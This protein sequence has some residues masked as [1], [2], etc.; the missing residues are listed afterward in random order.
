MKTPLEEVAEDYSERPLDFNSENDLQARLYEETREYLNSKQELETTQTHGFTIQDD[1]G[2]P[3]YAQRYHRDLESSLKQAPLSRVRTELTVW[4]PLGQMLSSDERPLD[5][6]DRT[7]ILDLAVLK[8]PF[9]RPVHLQNGRH[10]IEIEMVETAVE[11]KYPRNLPCMPS[12]TQGSIASL[13]D[14]EL[15]QTVDFE[16]VGIAADIEELE[17]LGKDYTITP[18]LFIS[19]QYD[20]FRR[21]RYTENRHQLLADAAV[22]KLRN[23]CSRT[24]V[25]YS[26]PD[27]YEWLV[28]H[29]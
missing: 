14:A 24:S 3:A 16:R 15:R 6:D 29:H 20:I 5:K 7:E 4:H 13:S 26:Y 2:Q 23:K 11:L 8:D 21:G 22:E 17:S 25:L 12:N 27:G 18:Y 28:D 19:S 9:D 10:R 1:G